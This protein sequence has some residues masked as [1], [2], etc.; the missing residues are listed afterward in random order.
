MAQLRDGT[1]AVGILGSTPLFGSNYTYFLCD[2]NLVDWPSVTRNGRAPW[3]G[4]VYAS[5]VGSLTPYVTSV[6]S[7]SVI[8]PAFP[9]APVYEQ[10]AD[11]MRWP[12]VTGNTVTE[13]RKPPYLWSATDFAF[14]TE[15]AIRMPQAESYILDN[16]NYRY[17]LLRYLGGDIDIGFGGDFFGSG[18][19][20]W[21]GLADPVTF[22]CSTFTAIATGGAGTSTTVTAAMMAGFGF[23][24]W[25]Q[26][27][28]AAFYTGAGVTPPTALPLYADPGDYVVISPIAPINIPPPYDMPGIDD[29]LPGGYLL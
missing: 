12:I 23:N 13:I 22:E 1:T 28:Y 14:L 7:A 24:P 3:A 5:L 25:D 26:I 4:M 27:F 20:V 19:T 18:W 8:D 16:T 2:P 6:G 29:W 17:Y 15:T 21:A 9:F 10:R 11:E